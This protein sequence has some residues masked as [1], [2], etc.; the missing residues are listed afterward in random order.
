MHGG[1]EGPGK[2]P[3]NTTA[4]MTFAITVGLATWA[5]VWLDGKTGLLPLF[6]LIGL[7]FGLGVGGYWLYIRVGKPPKRDDPPR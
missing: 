1:L 6:T 5:G 3:D 2:R 7:S 4:G